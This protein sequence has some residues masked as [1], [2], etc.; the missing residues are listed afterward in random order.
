MLRELRSVSIAETFSRIASFITVP[1]LTKSLIPAKYGLYK[2]ILLALS[3]VLIL[4]GLAN[5][6]FLIQ[7]YLPEKQRGQ[8][9]VLSAAS[10]V[11]FATVCLSTIVLF[12]LTILGV[13]S[14]ISPQIQSFASQNKYLVVLLILTLPIYRFMTTIHRSL[15]KFRLYSIVKFIREF[16]F[17]TSIFVL[18]STDILTVELAILSI[19]TANIIGMLASIPSISKELAT[20]DFNEFKRQFTRVSLPL[21]PRVIIKKISAS[22]PDVIVLAAFGTG[23]F[24]KWSVIFVFATVMSMLSQPFSQ[25]LL[26][27]LSERFKQN[28]PFDPI[29]T[30]YYRVLIILVM[31]AIIGGWMIGPNIIRELFG[32]EYLLSKTI[33]GILIISFGIQVIN[34]LSGYFFVATDRSKYQIYHQSLGGVIR[35]T[36]AAIGALLLESLTVIAI[37][38]VIEQVSKT[39]FAVWY[40]SKWV[41]FSTPGY[42]T[43][44]KLV[45]PLCAL[46][47]FA[48]IS[49]E[50]I[51]NISSMLLIVSS[52]ALVYFTTLH[53]TGFVSQKDKQILRRFV[54]LS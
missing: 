48:F 54:G 21:V 32:E 19:V 26:P 38:F 42:H 35:L 17:L 45:I 16:I 24:G 18:F 25:V 40:Q 53:F 36:F 28:E 44:I 39:S 46:S 3:L 29:I 27:K 13:F 37:G 22:G 41:N 4:P 1:L 52:N 14:L 47:A 34:T 7:K 5:L 43:I 51:F 11:F 6:E 23:I 10:I 20:P 2:S 15:L 30:R 9:G 49:R 8:K 31:P 50:Y 33:V 12:F